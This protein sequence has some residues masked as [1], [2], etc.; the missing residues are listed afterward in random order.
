MPNRPRARVQPRR[1]GQMHATSTAR[2][3]A[4]R[5]CLRPPHRQGQDRS[6][7]CAVGHRGS[8]K[9]KHEQRSQTSHRADR[10]G[11]Q[12]RNTIASARRV[13][14]VWKSC[15][16]PSSHVWKHIAASIQSCT[17]DQVPLPRRYPQR[18]R[19]RRERRDARTPARRRNGAAGDWGFIWPGSTQLEELSD[20]L[21]G[22][23]VT[24]RFI[25]GNHDDHV[26]LKKLRGRVRKR[27]VR[28]PRT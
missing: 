7:L 3:S 14:D 12:Q 25:D 15:T 16:A 28:S 2:R 19:L 4:V 5:I 8:T 21:V 11:H 13:S 17:N 6:A 24:M 23:G 9:N 10:S 22:L 1:I 20:M 27:G 26:K 18:S